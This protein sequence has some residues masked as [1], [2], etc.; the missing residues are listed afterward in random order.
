MKVGG[1]RRK[2]QDTIQTLT[3]YPLTPEKIESDPIFFYINKKTENALEFRNPDRRRWL[4][5]WYI[6][7]N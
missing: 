2:M 3:P 1:I 4:G 7:I 6:K 5:S